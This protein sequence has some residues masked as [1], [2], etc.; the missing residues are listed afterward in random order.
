LKEYASKRGVNLTTQKRRTVEKWEEEGGSRTE[1]KKKK[2]HADEK[3]RLE[4][5]HYVR[6]RVHL[7]TAEGGGVLIR[8]EVVEG[9][10][11]C[12]NRKHGGR[13]PPSLGASA[14]GVNRGEKDGGIR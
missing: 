5:G 4:L 9:S 14:P 2:G 7:I 6:G 3:A 13:R 10:G 11:G 12:E 1:T 8:R